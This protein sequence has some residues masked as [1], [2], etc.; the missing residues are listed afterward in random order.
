M[1]KPKR[2]SINIMTYNEERCIKRCI[3]SILAL[4]DEIV[5]LDTGSSDKTIDIIKSYRSDKIKLFKEKWND[6]FSEIR[7]KMIAAS[8]KDIIFQIDADEYLDSSQDMK[9]IKEI[10]SSLD[11]KLAYSP[12]IVDFYGS[13][14]SQSL[15]RI[16]FNNNQF[17]YFGRI[18]EELRTYKT[19]MKS[20]II[21]LKIMHDGYLEDILKQK[22]KGIRNIG[23]SE[24]MMETE[25]DNPRWRYYYVK[26][27]FHYSNDTDL[28]LD[29]VKD[30]LGFIYNKK[31]E[32]VYFFEI[33]K[34]IK[35]IK[36]LVYIF[37]E[38][39]NYKRI[40][41]LE[42]EFGKNVDSV[43]LKLSLLKNKIEKLSERLNSYFDEFSKIQN[44]DDS[45]LN[46]QGDHVLYRLCELFDFF[47]DFEKLETCLYKMNN[48]IKKEF[49]KKNIKKAEKCYTKIKKN[50]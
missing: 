32:S 17:Y 20:E 25:P 30:F 27:L 19:N 15:C 35:F 22:N 10:F 49:Y 45:M 16:F 38:R 9:T 47:K 36:E 33:Y 7:N 29:R 43:F 14:Y 40:S 24:K 48:N 6:D 26:D 34:E 5:I 3:D 18:H 28:L 44:F 21:E 11:K 23:L 8:S 1:K 42:K 39:G 50:I 13:G 2:I 12:K 37:T 31:N 41:N 4:A 46:D